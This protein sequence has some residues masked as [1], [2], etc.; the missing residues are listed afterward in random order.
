MRCVLSVRVIVVVRPLQV[1]LLF[2]ILGFPYYY[3]GGRYISI[4]TFKPLSSVNINK[5][6]P[7]AGRKP[8]LRSTSKEHSP[9]I[10]LPSNYT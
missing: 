7:L 2:L 10:M 1:L 5:P 6:L 4:T 8:T 3:A 9:K